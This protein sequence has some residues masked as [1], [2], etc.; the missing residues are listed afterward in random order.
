MNREKYGLAYKILWTAKSQCGKSI[1]KI[2]QEPGETASLSTISRN[3]TDLG[4]YDAKDKN[5][6]IGEISENNNEL[7]IL[8]DKNDSI[9]NKEN[10]KSRI[11][12]FML[13]NN[14]NPVKDDSKDDLSLIKEN[15]SKI[16]EFD[17]INFSQGPENETE[18]FKI[19][20]N[21]RKV[22]YENNLE[23]KNKLK[24]IILEVIRKKKLNV[25]L[26]ISQFRRERNRITGNNSKNT[27]TIIKPFGEETDEWKVNLRS[28]LDEKIKSLKA[29]KSRPVEKNEI[30]HSITPLKNENGGQIG[31][32]LV[33]KQLDQALR[34]LV[35][36][37]RLEK[38]K[39]GFYDLGF[40]E[41]I[42][43][44]RDLNA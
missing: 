43:L 13:E 18:F 28:D 40:A 20:E 34:E 3:I 29:E 12:D 23:F 30:F 32:N 33:K 14:L 26:K 19:H 22:T 10:L 27:K 24:P 41:K 4:K 2:S 37:D 15:L 7:S 36:N 8:N 21:K 35:E 44:Y 6:L 16:L 42:K 5:Q 38:D 11:N 25:D 1:N 39:K 9:H 31:K 17:L